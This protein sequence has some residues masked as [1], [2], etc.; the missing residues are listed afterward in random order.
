MGKPN[1]ST[2]FTP[3]I[4]GKNRKSKSKSGDREE[5]PKNVP[6]FNFLK[7][8]KEG[9]KV[10]RDT[11]RVF[12]HEAEPHESKNSISISIQNSIQVNVPHDT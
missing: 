7:K 5:R 1:F 10:Q 12:L 2:N 9:K 11:A 3:K 6:I 4:G 8:D